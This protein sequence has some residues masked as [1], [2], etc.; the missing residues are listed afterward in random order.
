MVSR[1]RLTELVVLVLL[2]G[3]ARVVPARAGGGA[4]VWQA[5][6]AAVEDSRRLG[7][8]GAGRQVFL[9]GVATFPGVLGWNC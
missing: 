3:L 4:A 5:G 8:V 2:L 9:G 7:R 6:E 1:K